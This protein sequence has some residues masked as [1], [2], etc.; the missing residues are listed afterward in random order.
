[1]FPH[2]RSPVKR[3]EGKPFALIGI[4]SDNDKEF[5]KKQNEKQEVTWRAAFAPC[6]RGRRSR[7][8]LNNNSSAQTP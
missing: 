8:M 3:L 6:S 4:N 7:V 2:E 5:A 1:M